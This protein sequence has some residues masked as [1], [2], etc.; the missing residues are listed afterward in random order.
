MTARQ[1]ILD[2]ASLLIHGDRQASYGSPSEN[3]QR[4][5]DRWTQHL[6]VSIAPWQVCILM[7]DLKLARLANGYHEDSVIDAVGYLA[8]AA[9]MRQRG[10]NP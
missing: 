8:L 9:E 5:A 4:I 3:F 1:D 10:G 6:G 2:T 7:A